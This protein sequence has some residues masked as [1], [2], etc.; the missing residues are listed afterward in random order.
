MT[1]MLVP[2]S[3]CI[4]CLQSHYFDW[5]TVTNEIRAKDLEKERLLHSLLGYG[6]VGVFLNKFRFW[7]DGKGNN[8]SVLPATFAPLRMGLIPDFKRSIY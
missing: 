3:D 7:V 4:C 8:H 2:D 5:G 1:N 6:R